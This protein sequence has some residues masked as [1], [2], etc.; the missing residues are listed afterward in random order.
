MQ[1]HSR[2]LT[3]LRYLYESTDQNHQM[4]T[5]DIK[6]MLEKDGIEAPVSRTIDSDVDQIISAGHK[7][8]K[9]HNNGSPMFYNVA[10]REFSAIELQM[11][12][13]AVATSRY[14]S[15]ER[16]KQ[17]IGKLIAMASP[18][19]RP[20]LETTLNQTR[21]IKR[22]MGGTLHV[23]DLVFQAVMEKKK[24]RFRLAS[25]EAKNLGQRGKTCKA[26][27]Y[28]TVYVNDR[29]YLVAYDEK[30]KCI[31]T[32][33]LDD[34]RKVKVL[35]E[36]ITPAPEGFDLGLCYSSISSGTD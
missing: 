22:A 23:P 9:T 15:V 29:Y 7:V 35:F 20:Y 28:G 26:S 18:T 2:I 34:I 27:P 3:I 14:I 13:D 1:E 17:I 21:T 25:D 5:K 19:E 32:P 8:V 12:I 11:I 6:R 31:I 10:E 4:S 36:A 24:I 16:S 33:R 30:Q